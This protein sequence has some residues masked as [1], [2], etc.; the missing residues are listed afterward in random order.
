MLGIRSSREPANASRERN[1]PTALRVLATPA[2][3][4]GFSGDESR[5]EDGTEGLP[6]PCDPPLVVARIL[7]R[8]SESH[9]RLAPS[10]RCHIGGRLDGNE[11][12]ACPAER[13]ELALV[14]GKDVL[15]GRLRA[16]KATI[17]REGWT[18]DSELAF[19]CEVA[20]L[21]RPGHPQT[22]GA[23]RDELGALDRRMERTDARPEHKP[24][25]DGRAERSTHRTAVYQ[26]LQASPSG[27]K[28]AS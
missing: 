24:K 2:P 10:A 23:V 16:E 1:R 5:I 4:L 26:M 25:E 13:R 6:G 15:H 22:C 3:R 18:F 19:A 8:E 17:E 27:M 9:T 14:K 11:I 7:D 20:Q 21:V 28:K 12:I